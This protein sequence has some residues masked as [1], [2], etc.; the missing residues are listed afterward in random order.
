MVWFYAETESISLT[1][2]KFV[3]H[4]DLERMHGKPSKQTILAD[5]G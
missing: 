4:S 2:T 1:P 5:I 3:K